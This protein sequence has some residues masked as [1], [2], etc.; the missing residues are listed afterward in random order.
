MNLTVHFKSELLV[1]HCCSLI[2]QALLNNT[3][4]YPTL[5]SLSDF[6]LPALFKKEL[7]PI[8][9]LVSTIKTD[10][11]NSRCLIGR[12]VSPIA[13]VI[14]KMRSFD[15]SPSLLPHF[16]YILLILLDEC[17]SICRSKANVL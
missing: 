3:V 6:S 14:T 11:P 12:I 4:C 10:K 1:L 13:S 15:S 5:L 16:H 2:F 17:I 8:A 7:N 9:K